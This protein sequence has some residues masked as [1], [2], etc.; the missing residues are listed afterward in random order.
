MDGGACQATIHGVTKSQTQLSDF[1]F[2]SFKSK[3][4]TFLET[5]HRFNSISCKTETLVQLEYKL[6]IA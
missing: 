4:A 5:G 6:Q 1:T 2:P 3:M